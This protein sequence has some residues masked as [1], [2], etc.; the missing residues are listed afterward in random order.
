MSLALVRPRAFL[1]VNSTLSRQSSAEPKGS[2][3][4][5]ASRLQMIKPFTRRH[6]LVA[7]A[8]FTCVIV[9]GAS[10]MDPGV[11]GVYHDDGMKLVLL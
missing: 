6:W 8:L 9:L 11:S 1:S 5:S 10:R 7:A 4:Q 3:E 2:H